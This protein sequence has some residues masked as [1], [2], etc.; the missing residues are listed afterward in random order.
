MGLH[1]LLFYNKL[2]GRCKQQRDTAVSQ[3]DIGA[4]HLHPF[5]PYN[6][7]LFT[8]DAHYSVLLY[9]TAHICTVVVELYRAYFVQHAQ[10]ER[11]DELFLLQIDA[12]SITSTYEVHT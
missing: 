6:V 10:S 1:L 5:A 8:H 7:L 11:P 3:R 9:S 12:R 4:S 2:I